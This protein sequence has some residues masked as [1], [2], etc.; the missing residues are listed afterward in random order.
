MKVLDDEA[1]CAAVPETF[2]CSGHFPTGM[3]TRYAG[4]QSIAHAGY[5]IFAAVFRRFDV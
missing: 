3:G 2:D 1:M 4:L 5:G